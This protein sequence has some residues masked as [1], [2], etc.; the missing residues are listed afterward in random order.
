[1]FSRMFL[2]D[3]RR[4]DLFVNWG[5]GTL[6]GAPLPTF[7]TS[8]ALPTSASFFRIPGGGAVCGFPTADSSYTV[9][10]GLEPT[11]TP[12]PATLLLVGTGAAGV[13]LARWWKR[14]RFHA[15]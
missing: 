9:S 4:G 7:T 1:M 6:N 11:P 5:E 13:G 14:R 10:F 12:E 2:A 3:L 8:G 15:S